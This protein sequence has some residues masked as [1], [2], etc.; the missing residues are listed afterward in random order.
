MLFRFLAAATCAA[1]VLVVSP[2]ARAEIPP[3]VQARYEAV[4]NRFANPAGMKAQPD[5]DY[6]TSAYPGVYELRLTGRSGAPAPLV[7]MPEMLFDS[8][9]KWILIFK[10]PNQTSSRNFV[11][12]W[13]VGDT[14]NWKG[15]QP[16]SLQD[17]ISQ[18]MLRTIPID[19]LMHQGT[20]A[21]VFIYYAAPD[22]PYC[23][24]DQAAMEQSP[25]SFAIM[26]VTLNPASMPYVAHLACEDDPLAAWNRLMRTG[27]GSTQPCPRFDV[28]TW[29]DIR[30]LFFPNALTPS[31]LFADGTVIQGDVNAAMRK[32]ADMQAR[33]MVFH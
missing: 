17:P 4:A 1:L 18:Q 19:K 11:D 29:W 9:A 7:G 31:F 23:K 16:V 3:D 30:Q 26:P 15:W 5:Q 6:D 24:K 32:A 13:L 2:G 10:A 20:G 8:D 25:F 14:T 33:G 27:Q 12:H 21:P 22:C 28:K